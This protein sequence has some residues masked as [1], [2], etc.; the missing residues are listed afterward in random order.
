MAKEKEIH[1]VV[2]IS[3]DEEDSKIADKTLNRK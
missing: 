1:A 3:N 2:S